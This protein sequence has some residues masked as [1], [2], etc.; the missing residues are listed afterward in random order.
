LNT[1][2]GKQLRISGTARPPMPLGVTSRPAS[3]AL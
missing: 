2:S 1:V 3:P